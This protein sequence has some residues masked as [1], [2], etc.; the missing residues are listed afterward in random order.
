MYVIGGGVLS[1]FLLEFTKIGI[2]FTDQSFDTYSIFIYIR[3][4]L[5]QKS[6]R[7]VSVVLNQ[8]TRE[9]I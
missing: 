2:C 3:C 6:L 7:S 4:V 8:H 1:G 5:N 9:L